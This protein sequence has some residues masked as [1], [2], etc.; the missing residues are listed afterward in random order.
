M[1]LEK[2]I[3]LISDAGTEEL[4]ELIAAIVDR[5]KKLYPDWEGMYLSFPLNDS[6]ECRRIMERA[7]NFLSEATER[8]VK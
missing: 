7:W 8:S 1:N 3:E 2:L 6:D 5:Q 4:T